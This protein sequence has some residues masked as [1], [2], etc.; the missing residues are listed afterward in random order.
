MNPDPTNSASA[1]QSRFAAWV[2]ALGCLGLL[3]AWGGLSVLLI[4]NA[5]DSMA[6][7]LAPATGIGAIVALICGLVHPRRGW[8]RI[9]VIGGGVFL[10][11]FVLS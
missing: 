7:L 6:A 5:S 3:T 4:G 1:P 10:G 11:L 8:T 2:A 9:L